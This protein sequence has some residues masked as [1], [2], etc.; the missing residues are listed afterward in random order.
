MTDDSGLRL[1][2]NVLVCIL[3]KTTSVIILT[4]HFVAFH[5]NVIGIPQSLGCMKSSQITQRC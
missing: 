2:L 5:K 3:D 4:E 1:D